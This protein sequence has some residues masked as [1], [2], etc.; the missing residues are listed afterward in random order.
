M[1]SKIK[2]LGMDFDATLV[3]FKAPSSWEL[4]DRE[5][6]CEEE[7]A[8]LNKEYFDGKVD[9]ATWSRKTTDLYKKYGLTLGRFQEIIRKNMTPMQ[10]IETLFKGSGEKG[11]KTAVISGT[12][13]NAYDIFVD[14]TGLRPDFEKIAHEFHFDK[15]GILNG[16]SFTN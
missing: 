8:K 10:G 7:D 14:T 1:K 4:L 11:I 5:L 3:D 16:G 12:I 9:I 15:Q 2:L 6:R 13:K